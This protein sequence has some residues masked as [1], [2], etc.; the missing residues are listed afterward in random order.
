M[1]I[2]RNTNEGL[3]WPKYLPK[4]DGA[5]IW[6]VVGPSVAKRVTAA[7]LAPRLRS[8]ASR[9]LVLPDTVLFLDPATSR[10]I[11]GRWKT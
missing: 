10:E 4:L 11:R 5:M 1:D 8:C 3:L 6:C 9:L 2:L 7:R